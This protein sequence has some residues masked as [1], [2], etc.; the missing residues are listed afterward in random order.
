MTM[1]EIESMMDGI[2]CSHCGTKFRPNR[3]WQRFC[4]PSCRFADW[5]KRNPRQREVTQQLHR[6]ESKLDLVIDS[7]GH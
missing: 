4:S 6:I 7:N 2:V 3:P 5:D 1:S